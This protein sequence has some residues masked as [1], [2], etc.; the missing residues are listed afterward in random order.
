VANVLASYFLRGGY[1]HE[2]I[3]QFARRQMESISRLAADKNYD[4]HLPEAELA[5]LPQKWAGK[6]ILRPEM[7]PSSGSKPLPLVHD[8]YSF[9]YLPAKFLTGQYQ[10]QLQDIAAYITDDRYRALPIGYGYIWPLANRGVCYGC[11]WSLELP[12]LDSADPHRQR[13]IVQRM[14]LLARF[15][16]A[17]HSSWFRQ[18]LQLLEAYRTEQGTYRF[19]PAYLVE[20]RSGYY[21]GGNYMGLEDNRRS[22]KALELESTFRMLLIQQQPAI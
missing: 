13:I 12:D 7:V 9:A 16:G 8:I 2:E 18:G 10:Y 5:G 20:Q 3:V 19:P 14:E 15:P 1:E 22:P 11:G 21:I 4:I 6:P 17:R